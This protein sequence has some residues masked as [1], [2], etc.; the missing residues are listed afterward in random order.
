MRKSG[1]DR[2]DW[3][4][5]PMT[6]PI[7]M[8]MIGVLGPLTLRIGEAETRLPSAVQE[9][10]LSLLALHAGTVVGPAEMAELLW[11]GA[12]PAAWR[13]LIQVYISRLRTFLEP[14]RLP[15]EASRIIISAGGG[16]RLE[17]DPESLDLARFTSLATLAE[18]AAGQAQQQAACELYEQALACWRGPLLA[19]GNPELQA[20]PAARAINLH[21]LAVTMSYAEV[22]LA[23]G[24]AAQ[25]KHWLRQVAEAE[26]LH[27][28]L[29]AQLMLALA[30]SGEQAAALRLYGDIR[31]RL[32]GQLGADPGPEL[33]HAHRRVLQGGAGEIPPRWEGLA[34]AP[35][36]QQP[37][38][39]PDF[40]GREPEIAL[41]SGLLTGAEPGRPSAVCLSGMG[42]IGKTSI[43]V[44]VAHLIRGHH[45]DGSLYLD[46]RGADARPPEPHQVM[47]SILRCL[48]L[49][50]AAIPDDPFAR[51]GLYRAV[52]TERRILLL[53]DNAAD[54][55]QVRP[56]IPPLPSCG[57]IIT[58]RRS[59]VGLD[60]V[61]LIELSGLPSAAAVRLLASVVGEP[62]VATD[63]AAALQLVELCGRLPLA[64]RVI[65]VRLAHRGTSLGAMAR[66]LTDGR[67]RLDELSL[68]D[69]DVRAALSVCIGRL[70]PPMAQLLHRLAL[71]AS[72]DSASWAAAALLEAPLPTAERM[73][74]RLVEASLLSARPDHR[75]VLHDLIRLCLREMTETPQDRSALRRAYQRLLDLANAADSGL[76]IRLYQTA[77]PPGPPTTDARRWL[78]AE[79]RFL[80]AA[81]HDAARRGWTGL[82]WRLLVAMTNAALLEIYAQEWI[83][84]AESMLT[85]M[86]DQAAEGTAQLLLALATVYQNRGRLRPARQQ[87]RRARRIFLAQGDLPNAV[88]CAIQ[89]SVAWRLHGNRRLAGAAADWAIAHQPVEPVTAQ[90][91]WAY[92]AR[93]NLLFEL[94]HEAV[95]AQDAYR[96]AL[97]VMRS[98][99]AMAGEGHALILLAR[100]MAHEGWAEAAETY[101]AGLRL[102]TEA[103][104]V[105]GLCLAQAGMAQA[106]LDR[107]NLAAAHEAA[108]IALAQAHELGTTQVLQI[109]HLL[110]GRI[111]SSRGE[112]AQ[113]RQHLL[114]AVAYARQLG[115][116]AS[117]AASLLQLGLAYR[118]AGDRAAALPAVREARQLSAAQAVAR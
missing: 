89:L 19:G 55:Q 58:S 30:G 23:L 16:Y 10:L 91:G 29:H 21:R 98:A 85:A 2:R 14:S 1:G 101:G 28:T 86:P 49:P 26:P 88:S 64:L 52:L 109:T 62:A 115:S 35:V 39:L 70:K 90:L 118:A 36:W 93:G 57:L 75:Y 51:A 17:L 76:P 63:P 96:S 110:C 60:G 79:H 74:D 65:A 37:A 47:G 22:A 117:L 112:H 3:R 59:L 104:D 56:L 7:V 108:G 100:A 107:G 82:G 78:E 72:A 113:A 45:P 24:R 25:A 77:A 73:L 12:V 111:A 69:R 116:P 106:H 46:L 81:A 99:G 32:A 42:G 48:G 105:V 6:M 40:T 103:G 102:L 92:L 38:T 114:G 80:L 83:E 84:A 95:A 5:V 61:H 87:L 4:E 41:M 54:E 13:N 68:G 53:L 20:H 33:R 66:R 8:P 11:P 43:A 67:S 15:R 44:R 34:W 18:R 9:S 27:E 50:G 97:E 31:S 94:A 71:F